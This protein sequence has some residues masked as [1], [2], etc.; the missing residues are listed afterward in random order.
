MSA[1]VKSVTYFE[2]FDH[3]VFW[4]RT[5]D[6]ELKFAMENRADTLPARDDADAARH[7][8]RVGHRRRKCGQVVVALELREVRARADIDRFRGRFPT[9]FRQQDAVSG[10]R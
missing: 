5:D 7:D 6:I 8:P 1:P 10:L 3:I 2:H 9:G 4:C